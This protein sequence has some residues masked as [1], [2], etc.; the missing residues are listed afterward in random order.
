MAIFNNYIII[1][2]NSNMRRIANKSFPVLSI[3]TVLIVNIVS[4]SV[5]ISSSQVNA[6][7]REVSAE[8]QVNVTSPAVN[9]SVITP[10]NAT[11][12]ATAL[13]VTGLVSATLN[14]SDSNGVAVNTGPL[15]GFTSPVGGSFVILSDGFASDAD[16]PEVLAN[17]ELS[18]LNN[19]AGE[20]LVQLEMVLT[21]PQDATCFKMNVIFYSE[22]YP[23]WVGSYFNDTFIAE[24]MPSDVAS[25]LFISGNVID[26]PYNIGYDPTGN[27]VSVNSPF[28]F[29]A[30]ESDVPYNGTSGHLM[31]QGQ[32]PSLGLDGNIKIV[33]SITDMGDSIVDSAVFIDNFQWG[34]G[35]NCEQGTVEVPELSVE[36]VDVEE[37]VCTYGGAVEQDGFLVTIKDIDTDEYTIQWRWMIPGTSTYTSWEELLPNNTWSV[38]DE[39]PYGDEDDYQY[40]L[41]HTEGSA[42]FDQLGE[43]PGDFQ[44][45]AVDTEGEIDATANREFTF[46][47]DSEHAA[48]NVP[49]GV[50]LGIEKEGNTSV[51]N[52]GGEV[53]FYLTVTNSGTGISKNVIVSDTLPDGM[54]YVSGDANC[55]FST[56]DKYLTCALGDIEEE[57][58]KAV[59]FVVQVVQ[60]GSL[61]NT[62]TVTT[63]T[64]EDNTSNNSSSY[65]VNSSEKPVPPPTPPPVSP[66]PVVNHIPNVVLYGTAPAYNDGKINIEAGESFN[67]VAYI[68]NAGDPNYE[69]SFGGVCS[70]YIN[71]S[72][73]VTFISNPLNLN[74]GTYSCW[75]T[76]KDGNG[77]ISSESVSIVVS[78]GVNQI[79]EPTVEEEEQEEEGGEGEG[80]VL[81]AI[82]CEETFKLSGFVYERSNEN[83][84]KD[85]D[86]RELIDV[87]VKIYT[88]DKD[89]ERVLVTEVKTNSDGYWEVDLCPGYYEVELSL[90]TVEAGIQPVGENLRKI[91]IESEDLENVNFEFEKKT[92]TSRYLCCISLIVILLITLLLYILSRRKEEEKS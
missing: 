35:E 19:P 83:E 24:A 70:G 11:E 16:D 34:Y 56:D 31:T 48:C 76:V 50:D 49:I 79:S 91:T 90:E 30:S 92:D 54:K 36:V 72:S 66:S 84:I 13:D 33:L 38:Y 52:V 4:F 32:I 3:F 63:D 37:R 73:S 1:M 57:G 59:S 22:E 68:N 40:M 71:N 85:E 81:A 74:E 44:I 9:L 28:G 18:G 47:D 6:Q 88:Y 61:T 25:S 8:Q 87:N 82:S 58:S 42:V 10:A 2:K 17:H 62:A 51:V 5:T 12:L 46:T 14:G 15:G 69:Y 77:D 20:D 27:P 64:S 43:V 60:S 21:P 86:E 65:T 55:M 26:S 7:S 75:V 80:E 23:Q 45:R 53:I 29:M 78:S 39:L 89:G 67:V 41:Y